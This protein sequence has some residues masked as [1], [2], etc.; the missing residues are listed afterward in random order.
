MD[1]RGDLH[2]MSSQLA[3]NVHNILS[4]PEESGKDKL[5]IRNHIRL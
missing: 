5:A 4:G 2:N 3:S 1:K